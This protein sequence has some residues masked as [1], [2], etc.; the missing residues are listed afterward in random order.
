MTFLAWV[1]WSNNQE[2]SLMQFALLAHSGGVFCLC[3][4]SVPS[5]TNIVFLSVTQ[6]SFIR[7]CLDT[8]TC[9]V[10]QLQRVTAGAT[11]KARPADDNNHRSSQLASQRPT[12]CGHF[13]LDPFDSLESHQCT[14]HQL[15]IDGS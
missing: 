4:I 3:D 13:Q 8:A 5:S 12:L 7:G 6:A 2:K 10:F 15:C 14:I 11:V 9:S 1:G